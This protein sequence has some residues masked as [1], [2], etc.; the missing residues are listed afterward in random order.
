[1]IVSELLLAFAAAACAVILIPGPTVLLVTGYALSGGLR[2]ALLSILGVCLG[3]AVA[4][5][6]T[7]LGLG[8]VLAASAELFMILKWLGAAYLVYL[9]IELW[10]SPVVPGASE[11][12][13]ESGLLRIVA[14]AFTVNV[15]HPKGLAFYAAFL[16]QFIDSARPA[17]PQMLALGATFMAIAA[18]V[19][20]AYAL[21]AARFRAILVR[22]EVQHAVNRTGAGCLIGA[23]LYTASL[24]R[25]G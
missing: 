12:Q 16:P 8:A 7:F 22:P 6:L 25:G 5:T 3:D 24:G 4:M 18:C 17:L 19:L 20:L 13:R 23:G 2:T 1:M 9:G 11:A 15:V 10:R 21:A 14:R